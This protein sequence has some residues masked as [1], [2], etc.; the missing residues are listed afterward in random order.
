MAKCFNCKMCGLALIL[1]FF[2]VGCNA[3]IYVDN[4]EVGSDAKT[5]AIQVAS[6]ESEV[7]GLTAELEDA[8]MSRDAIAKVAETSSHWDSPLQK[9]QNAN[10]QVEFT[11]RRLTH[12]KQWLAKVKAAQENV[13]Q[14]DSVGAGTSKAIQE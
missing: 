9:V 13:R 4:R 12:A 6:A 3:Q 8:R 1:F 10:T 11:S 7:E 14:S 2:A 5:L